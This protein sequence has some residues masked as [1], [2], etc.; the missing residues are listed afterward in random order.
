[1]LLTYL[2]TSK[3]GMAMS[4]MPKIAVD[5]LGG[6]G[7]RVV[8]SLP[9]YYSLN[10]I[11]SEEGPEYLGVDTNDSYSLYLSNSFMEYQIPLMAEDR[12]YPPEL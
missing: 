9:G 5:G 12:G 8:A 2:G 4:E 11:P 3:R 7:C 1:M 6:F 10:I